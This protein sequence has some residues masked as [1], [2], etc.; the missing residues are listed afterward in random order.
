MNK[1]LLLFIL[2]LVLAPAKG[3]AVY[4]HVSGRSI[5]EF[6]DEMAGERYFELNSAVK[7]YTRSFIADKLAFLRDSVSTL[8]RRQ[9][10]ELSFYLRDYNKELLPGKTY[11]KRLD[12]FYYKDSLF[13]FSLNPILGVQFWN[14][15]NGGNFHRW[16]GAEVFAY[17]G[18]H[19]GIYA[20]LRDNHEKM[21][22][23]SPAFL[24]TR[25]GAVY[26]SGQDY[27]EMRG[28]ITWSW[29]WGS[30][31]LVKDHA[32]WGTNYRY[33][34][35]LSARAPSFTQLKL[36]LTPVRW[37]EFNYVHGW[38]VSGVIDSTR[39][40]WFTNSYGTS[41]RKVFRRKHI[42]TNLFTFKPMK[43]LITSIGN[44]IV[45]SDTEVQP[46]YL[47]PFFL[48]KSVD[49]TQI[50]AGDNMLGSNSQFFLDVSSRQIKHLH[51]YATVFFDDVSISRLKENGHLDYYSLNAGF[52][53][54]DLVPNTFFT[55]E[56]FQSYPL[57]YKHDMPT[58]TYESNFYNLGHYL[59]DNSKGLYISAGV[60][61]LRGLDIRAWVNS[62]RHGRDHES[63][64]TDRVD[65]VD[66][67]MDSITW[68]SVSAGL[69]VN[70]QLMND[71]FVFGSYTFR[72]DTGEIEKYTP[73]YL[74]NAEGTISVG[75]NI[76]L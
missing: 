20:S 58:T 39:S 28:G 71:V 2:V 18:E 6:L 9:Q 75:V 62:A 64:G 37:F 23:S 61:P 24:D 59:Q 40:Y 47:I 43:G 46:G 25:P 11:K 69:E 55:L 31:G 42:S 21:V 73:E 63:L 74:R 27:S 7:P 33:P 54:S 32:E 60:K 16:N 52:R 50:N 10:N 67:F 72:H 57:V 4:Q 44:S 68:K 22:L 51:L 14:N 12:L 45:Y 13:T 17:V 29:E 3:Q 34:S 36:T 56:Y 65:V 41:Y 48:Y 66:M 15:D 1:S 49:H 35:I 19:L 30:L 70:Y 53:L 38:L 5:Y 8:N 76:G 26:K